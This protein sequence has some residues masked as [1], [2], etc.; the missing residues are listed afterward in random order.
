MKQMWY[1]KKIIKIN[2]KNKNEVHELN[3]KLKNEKVVN[4]EIISKVDNI[5]GD[6]SI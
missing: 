2:S 1:F 6:A 5:T 3:K 4:V